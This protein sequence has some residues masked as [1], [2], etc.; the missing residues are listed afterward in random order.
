MKVFKFGGASVKD[1]D[2][3]R[4]VAKIIQVQ[5]AE[6]L[7]V[8]ISAMGKTT[9]ALEKLALSIW[10]QNYKVFT[11]V[12]ENIK[13]FHNNIADELFEKDTISYNY[14][15]LYALLTYLH[16]SYSK[17]TEKI[18]EP[19]RNN[20]AQFSDSIVS[21]G[22][23][24]STT[25]VECYL[26]QQKFKSVLLSASELIHTD[27]TYQEAQID[28]IKTKNAIDE[29]LLPLFKTHD[30][31]VTQG[32]IGGTKVQGN[33]IYRTTLGR[34]GSDFSA[35]IFAYCTGS[36]SVTI[37]KDVIGMF[38]SD[39]KKFPNVVKLDK[40]SYNEATEL[41][42]YGASVIHPK[43]LQPLENKNIPLFIKSFIAPH[44]K[45]TEIQ[46]SRAYDRLIPS[47]IVKS[48][49][50]LISFRT[51]NFSFIAE[52]HLGDIFNKLSE[53]RIKI[54]IMQNSALSFSIIVDY[55]K[56]NLDELIKTFN[57]DYEVRYNKNLE[58][59]TIRHYTQQIIDQLTKNKQIILQQHTRETMRIVVEDE[60]GN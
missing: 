37:W 32:F 43:T 47:F 35:S 46:H 4:N 27:D 15:P 13:T 42:Y 51:R 30:I 14:S 54:N 7:I 45:G 8:V 21:V 25:L 31:I 10:N 29:K 11:E 17:F 20:F 39:P 23:L 12:F 57:K 2:S 34:E 26:K 6:K 55:A 5:N 28:W 18:F 24:L 53:L 52:S 50:L 38:N 19:H 33:E 60:D 36:K 49:Q 16:D 22:E 48:N 58:L 9:N 41:A 56:I 44:T 59:I 3:V 40:I 1:A